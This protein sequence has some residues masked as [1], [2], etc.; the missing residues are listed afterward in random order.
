MSDRA[1]YLVSEKKVHSKFNIRDLQ[2]IIKAMISTEFIMHMA[3]K[4]EKIYVRLDMKA[5]EEMISKCKL[6][7]S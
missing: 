3:N 2:Y 6:L 5:R 1:M 4:K 7:F